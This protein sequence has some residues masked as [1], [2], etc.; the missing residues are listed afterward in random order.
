[1]QEMETLTT[2]HFLHISHYHQDAALQQKLAQCPIGPSLYPQAPSRDNAPGRGLSAAWWQEELGTRAGWWF[3]P[4][5]DRNRIHAGVSRVWEG[6]SLING[7]E[8]KG[9]ACHR[10]PLPPT[11]TY[12][13]QEGGGLV[14]PR[15]AGCQACWSRPAPRP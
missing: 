9:N 4:F 15:Q 10:R 7:G 3:I 13:C 8:E 2:S 14:Q 11:R 1:M 5:K 12:P 6:V